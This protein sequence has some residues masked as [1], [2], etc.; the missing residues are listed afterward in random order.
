VD[1]VPF[2]LLVFRQG[3]ADELRRWLA[4]RTW[5]SEQAWLRRYFALLPSAKIV[6]FEEVQKQIEAGNML[7]VRMDTVPIG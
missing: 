4:S 3:D 7:W 5:T 2:V 1:D 6:V